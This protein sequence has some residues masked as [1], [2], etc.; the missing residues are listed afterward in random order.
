MLSLISCEF[1]C[2]PHRLQALERSKQNGAQ[3]AEQLLRARQQLQSA[4]E[5]GATQGRYA[6]LVRKATLQYTQVVEL[7]RS[8]A[9][10]DA[11]SRRVE[12]DLRLQL[13]GAR[14]L[15][16]V[17][18]RTAHVG[19]L[20]RV[21]QLRREELAFYVRLATR[22]VPKEADALV[23]AIGGLQGASYQTNAT[24][25]GASRPELLVR[26][27][28]RMAARLLV[29]LESLYGEVSQAALGDPR[30]PSYSQRPYDRDQRDSRDRYPSAYG[31]Q[32]PLSAL[33]R[34]DEKTGATPSAGNPSTG[35]RDFAEVK[36]RYLRRTGSLKG[37]SEYSRGTSAERRAE[38][39]PSLAESPDRFAGV[40]MNFQE[41]EW[42]T[43]RSLGTNRLQ[44]ERRS[45][46]DWERE[47]AALRPGLAV[48]VASPTPAAPSRWRD[49]SLSPPPQQPEVVVSAPEDT[50]SASRARRTSEWDSQS[51]DRFSPTEY[52][53]REAGLR[54][55]EPSSYNTSSLSSRVSPES[56]SQY[57]SDEWSSGRKRDSD[58]PPLSEETRYGR[59]NDF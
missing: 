18:R 58:R 24:A 11:E 10:V 38:P 32:Q 7:E 30:I 6:V 34:L 50:R 35:E 1:Y 33:R 14:E 55:Q 13:A 20:V 44:P 49:P 40:N 41:R 39:P 22:L 28:A 45:E 29:L 15:E 42:P 21:G 36:A 56:R 54:H 48:P 3:A 26:R 52:N 2:L 23:G 46:R 27:E 43:L 12:A 19:E 37:P 5:L 59:R 31:Q 47:R 25:A 17:R 51:R 9:R 53:L 16:F 8:R 57:S 4:A